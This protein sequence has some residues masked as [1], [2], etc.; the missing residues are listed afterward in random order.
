MPLY[1]LHKHF[2]V[3]PVCS[4]FLLFGLDQHGEDGLTAAGGHLSDCG[5]QGVLAS[6]NRAVR[7]HQFLVCVHV[8]HGLTS[9]GDACVPNRIA[10]S[11]RQ[12]RLPASGLHIS[13]RL[14]WW[15]LLHLSVCALRAA[16]SEIF[17]FRFRIA[18]DRVCDRFRLVLTFAKECRVRPLLGRCD[19]HGCGRHGTIKL[20]VG[21]HR[22]VKALTDGGCQVPILQ[23]FVGQLLLFEVVLRVTRLKLCSR[24]N[25]LWQRGAWVVVRH[26]N[27]LSKGARCR[28]HLIL[29][30]VEERLLRMVL[31][32][33]MVDTAS[34]GFFLV[35]KQCCQFAA[36]GKF[37]A[38]LVGILRDIECR[39]A[40]AAYIRVGDATI[41]G[42]INSHDGRGEAA[43]LTKFFIA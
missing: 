37:W 27:C 3:Q 4:V 9:V 20:I 33:R 26:L 32:K 43:I 10:H 24:V 1:R 42:S 2:V 28:R 16:V 30:V 40:T 14:A 41:T 38:L 31:T 21:G 19:R 34:F 39:W 18:D 29:H 7:L 17:L 11:V 23:R 5:R 25:V 8:H 35:V 36:D 15:L 22:H 6:H 13:L 12:V